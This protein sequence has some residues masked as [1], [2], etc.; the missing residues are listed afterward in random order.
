MYKVIPNSKKEKKISP[1]TVQGRV[2]LAIGNAIVYLYMHN[3][4][5]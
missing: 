2:E 3:W 4:V 5:H 1:L